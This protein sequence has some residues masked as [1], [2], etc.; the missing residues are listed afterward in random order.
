MRS[1]RIVHVAAVL[2]TAVVGFGAIAGCESDAQTGGLFGALGG[3]GLGAII[4]HQSGHAAEGAIIGGAAGGAGGYV[5]GNESD[6]AR[7]R[8]YEEY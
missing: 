7:Q 4:G 6:K 1:S 3:A 5:I 8:R 2:L